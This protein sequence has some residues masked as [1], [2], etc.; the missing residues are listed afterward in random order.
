MTMTDDQEKRM[1]LTLG[2][3]L[4][5][6]RKDKNLSVADVCTKLG[7]APFT[8]EWLI[9]LE[10]G[11]IGTAAVFLDDMVELA[12]LYQVSLDYVCGLVA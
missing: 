5:K 12:T 9:S 7:G 8:P 3:R 11:R 2:I 4:K 6:S 10:G 1:M